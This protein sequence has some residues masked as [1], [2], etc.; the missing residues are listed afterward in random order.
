MGLDRA[1]ASAH[2]RSAAGCHLLC[3]LRD[4]ADRWLI[5]FVRD[6]IEGV[7]SWAEVDGWLGISLQAAHE[8]FSPVILD[9][10]RRATQ[11]DPRA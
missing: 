1:P 5:I 3:D 6:A 11:D 7:H 9:M 10:A 8:R 4:E 2:L